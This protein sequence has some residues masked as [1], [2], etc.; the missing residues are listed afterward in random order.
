MRS[1]V[2]VIRS[3]RGS[4]EVRRGLCYGE[5]H[6]LDVGVLDAKLDQ[7]AVAGIRDVAD[8]ADIGAFE[9]L[10]NRIRPGQAVV[11]A[12]VHSSLQQFPGGQLKSNRV[13]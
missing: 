4:D 11:Q 7:P 5:H 10:I 6:V 1:I 9:I 3:Y 8:L 12:C 13:P 2:A